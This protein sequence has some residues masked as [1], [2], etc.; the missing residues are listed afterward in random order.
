ML[1]CE[2]ESMKNIFLSEG[3]YT[4]DPRDPGGPTN[5]G[6][7]IFD[8]NKYAAEFGWIVG[9]K[10]TAADIRAMPKW[11]AEKVYDAKYW[12][13]LDADA[14]PAGLDYVLVDYGVNSGIGRAGKVLRRL[15]GLP[16]NDYRVTAEVLAAVAKRK[17][18]D[19]INAINA[20]RLRFL[21]SLSTWSHFGPGWGRRVASVNAIA[22]HMAA[23][24]AANDNRPA[25]HV[26]QDNE[27]MAKAVVPAPKSVKA[28]GSAA[29][30]GA[31]VTV[32][33][34]GGHAIL[35]FGA[36]IGGVVVSVIAAEVLAARAQRKTEAATPGVPVVPKMA[37]AA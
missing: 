18:S 5:W 20:E 3:G 27:T 12:D 22:L 13:A 14:L 31:G 23:S 6:I 29:S 7:T 28:T 9:R 4:N 26:T 17:V 16:D 19:L 35:I 32:A 21:K 2:A 8:A 1:A 15:L 11:F 30:I 25:P 33:A 34:S 24:P 37:V 36:L 10:V